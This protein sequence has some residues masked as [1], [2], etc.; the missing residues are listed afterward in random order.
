MKQQGFT[1]IEL[2]VVIAIIAILAALLLPALARAKAKAQSAACLNNIKQLNIC[3]HLYSVDYADL[4]VPNN[5]VYGQNV[6]AAAAAGASWCV[7]S[8]RYDATTTNLQSGLLF[9]YNQSVAIYRCPAD[10]SKIEDQSGNQLPQLRNRSYNMSQSING[11]PEFDSFM[12][13]HIPCF[14]KSTQVRAPGPEQCLVF[15]DENEDT[16]L[17]S[18]FGMPTD[19]YDGSTAWWDMP[20]NRHTQ[21]ANLSFADGHVE[22]WRWLVPKI[23]V[24]FVQSIPPAE[25]PDY[26]RIR[27]ALK[28]NMN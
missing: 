13:R 6:G 8:A 16:L 28:Q 20:A 17:D 25:L 11:Y 5:S 21:G 18:E 15:I 7:G 10:L 26:Q 12:L 1:L 3:C 2:L 9:G 22:H 24:N 19:F 14:K 4:L 27:A 23:F